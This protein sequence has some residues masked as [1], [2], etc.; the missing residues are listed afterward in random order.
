MSFYKYLILYEIKPRNNSINL[1][2]YLDAD[3]PYIIWINCIVMRLIKKY[4]RNFQL[5]LHKTSEL[6]L[7]SSYASLKNNAFFE[8]FDYDNLINR[9]LKPPYLPPKIKLHIEKDIQKSI[10]V[11]KLIFEEIKVLNQQKIQ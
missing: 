9:E 11:G 5:F 2:S 3:D 4:R 7:G 6:R 8:R 1:I 10:Q